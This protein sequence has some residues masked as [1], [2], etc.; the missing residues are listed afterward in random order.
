M[1]QGRGGYRRRQ[2]AASG[3][4]VGRPPK[5]Q[6]PLRADKGIATTVLAMDGPPVH[7]RTCE[8]E[9]CR[10][11]KCECQHLK[12]DKEG[13]A[14]ITIECAHCRTRAD[15]AICR[16]EVCA[17][18]VHLAARDQRVSF[19]ARKYLTDRRDGKPAQGVFMGDTRESA[20]ELD[21]GDLPEL[22]AP[23]EPLAA[24]KPN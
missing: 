9:T 13:G 8:C 19:E 22:I 3:N 21:F 23:G 12:S 11:K 4:K 16:C 1:P 18:W 5:P 24:G 7:I 2:A 17:W 20:R 14:G 15:H 10:G 6:I